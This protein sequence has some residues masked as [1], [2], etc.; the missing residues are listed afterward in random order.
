M[1]EQKNMRLYMFV[2]E[3]NSIVMRISIAMQ[4]LGKHIS[5]KRTRATEGRPLRGNGPENTPP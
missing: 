4:R 3:M 1:E 2:H 5:P